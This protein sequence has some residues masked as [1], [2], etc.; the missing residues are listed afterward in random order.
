MGNVNTVINTPVLIHRQATLKLNLAC[1]GD[2]KEVPLMMSSH[3]I[4]TC[5]KML[6]I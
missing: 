3:S 6:S 5:F 2:S 1:N 4:L